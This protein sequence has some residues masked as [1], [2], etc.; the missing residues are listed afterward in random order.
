MERAAKDLLAQYHSRKISADTL[1]E[2]LRL[3]APNNGKLLLPDVQAWALAKPQSYAGHFVLGQ[4]YFWIASD[5]RGSKSSR[6]TSESQFAEMKRY[7]LMAREVQIKALSLEGKPYSSYR[8]LVAIAG[9]SGDHRAAADALNSAIQID[10]DAVDAYLLYFYY[11]S[12]RWGGSYEHLEDVLAYARTT[13]ISQKNV[14]ILESEV[15]TLRAKDEADF[16]RNHVKSSELWEA[17]YRKNPGRKQE[18]YLHRAGWQAVYAKQYARAIEMD[19]LAISE[20]KDEGQ[21]HF[22]RGAKYDE[23][24][25]DYKRAFDDYVESAKRGNM[26]GQNNAGYYLMTGKAGRVDLKEA[27]RYLQMSADQGYDH[28]REKLKILDDMEKKNKR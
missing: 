4:M 3:M 21:Y 9:M 11:N 10:P 8:A 16:N 19:S 7:L 6:E 5:S 26:Y 28:A 24:M 20:F 12:P 2:Q 13:K 18:S 25:Q 14:G 23:Y 27:R 15:L 1:T 17:A 22:S